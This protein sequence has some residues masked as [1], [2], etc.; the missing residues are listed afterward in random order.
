MHNRSNTPVRI[1]YALIVMILMVGASGSYVPMDQQAAPSFVPPADPLYSDQ[2]YLENLAGGVDINVVPA[3]T[4]GY[5]GKNVTIAIVGD[6]VQYNH[7][8]LSNQYMDTVSYDFIQHDGFP[9]PTPLLDI[10]ETVAAGI[11]AATNDTNCGVGVAYDA[12][13]AALRVNT[14]APLNDTLVSQALS[15][16]PETNYIYSNSW[17]PLDDGLRLQEPGPLTL[18]ALQNGVTNGRLGKG[19]IYVWAAG[20][21]LS[22]GGDVGRT[23]DNVNYDGYANSRFTIAVGSVNDMGVQT[24]YSEPGAAILITAPSGSSSTR[25]I[26]TT[27]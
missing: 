16:A 25:N 23:I 20:N 18:A 12:K 13:L 26:S 10:H 19:S 2:W 7:P 5:T 15:W 14:E 24:N 6:G 4:D 8:D 11:A 21:G 17:G 22:D 3:W 27:D 9:L 1:F